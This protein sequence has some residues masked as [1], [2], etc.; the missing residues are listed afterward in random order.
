VLLGY[1]AD[2]EKV[3]KRFGL[4]GGIP[5]QALF[6]KDGKRVWHS[7]EK[8]LTG[9]RAGQAHRDGTGEITVCPKS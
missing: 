3:A 6:G 4:D 2:E 8:E 7:E 5:F 1:Q 9:R